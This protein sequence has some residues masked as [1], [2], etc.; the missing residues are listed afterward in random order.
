MKNTLILQAMLKILNVA[1]K[2]DAAKSIAA[3]LSKGT[4]RMRNGDSPY[5]KIY[6]FEYNLFNQKC[7]MVM[8]SV[9][10]HLLSLEF[11]R[12][13]KGW[14]TCDPVELFHANIERSC[15]ENYQKIK[16][17]LQRE[18]RSCQKLVI[19]TDCDRE[20]ENIGFEI[21]EVCTAVR[22]NLDIYRAIFSEIT[23]SSIARSIRELKRPNRLVSDAVEVRKEL[24]LRIG[25]AFTR[26][27]TLRLTKVFPNQLAENLISYGSCQFPTLGFVVERYKDRENFISEP[28]WKVVVWHEKD[29]QKVEFMWDRVRLFDYQVCEMFYN[30]LISNPNATV[31][32][33][34]NKPK[35]KWRPVALDTIELEK[36]AS[37]KLKISAKETMTIAEK[38]YTKGLI[39]YPRTETNI[40]PKDFNLRGLI[41]NQIND[42]HW[43]QFAQRIIDRPNPR[44]GTKSDQAHPPIHPTKYTNGLQG[45]EAKIYEFIVRQFLACCSADAKGSETTVSIDISNEKFSASGLMVLE[46]NYLDVYPYEKW[47]DKEIP[48]FERGQV[49]VPKSIHLKEGKTEAP[50]LLTEADLIS[51]MEKHGIGTDATHAE[52]IETIKERRY[53][54]IEQNMFVPAELGLGLVEGYDSMGYAMSKPKLRSELEKDL[55]EICS[56]KKN[57][58]QVL[59]AQIKAYEECFNDAKANVEKLDQALSKYYGRPAL[60]VEDTSNIFPSILECSCKS[61]MVLRTKKDGK[62][63][64][65]GCRG[66]PSCNNAIWFPS[67][68]KQA[69]A[70]DEYCQNCHPKRVKKIRFKLER[71]A[72]NFT[73]PADYTTCVV[74]DV[75]FREALELNMSQ[76]RNNMSSTQSIHTNESTV[77]V[78]S[79]RSYSTSSQFQSR[80]QPQPAL[81][82]TNTDLS[83]DDD[84]NPIVCNCNEPAILLTVRKDGPNQGKQFY[85]CSKAQTQSPCDFF[86]WAEGAANTSVGTTPSR[87]VGNS[88]IGRSQQS[89]RNVTCNCNEEAK[90]LTV[91]KPGPNQGRKFFKCAQFSCDFFEWEDMPDSGSSPKDFSKRKSPKSHQKKNKSLSNE[92]KRRKC[93]NCG[94]EGHNR[95]NCPNE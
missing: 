44:N 27:Q 61:N 36:S 5:N 88:N 12:Q 72:I 32:S 9:S 3:I 50:R 70:T 16:Q 82:V 41:E 39:S 45:N 34:T 65:L 21:I 57:K 1:E 11:P 79:N 13:Y 59:E 63:F 52:H 85:K 18:V 48:V 89:S 68:I 29:N 20:G 80:T 4:S 87:P 22:A 69:T 51:L 81:S 64:Y 23:A 38:L 37:R 66:Y 67:S 73:I 7:L 55:Q 91:N 14:N 93:G 46:R 8:T 40:F 15:P 49:F 33:V 19:W 84:S 28:F 92:P 42:Q 95:K 43:G 76:S 83:N 86:I 35:N 6:E 71:T 74:C 56:G 77:R 53:V 30:R 24:D 90:L 10:G 17:T 58:D 25:A 54:N 62:G 94:Q 26:F 75:Q 47:S 2:N 31:Q 60:F 78:S